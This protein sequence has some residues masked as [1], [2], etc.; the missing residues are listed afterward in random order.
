M[1]AATANEIRHR[2]EALAGH[3]GK[4]RGWRAEIVRGA[5]TTGGG[6]AP[7]VELP[8]WLLAIEKDGLTPDALEA[9]LRGL[10]P[11][12]VARIDRDRVMLDLRTVSPDEDAALAALLAVV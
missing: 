10:S 3:L 2:S 5:S 7:G 1:L 11:P 8:T 6:S 4:I 9:R 12:V